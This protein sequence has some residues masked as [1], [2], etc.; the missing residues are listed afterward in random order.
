MMQSVL[1]LKEVEHVSP[2]VEGMLEGANLVVRL[3]HRARVKNDGF[4]FFVTISLEAE[5]YLHLVLLF[6]ECK[7]I[8][9][10]IS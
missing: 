2:G 3:S 7:P 4:V 1:H 9:F 6:G 5:P 10:L 8:P